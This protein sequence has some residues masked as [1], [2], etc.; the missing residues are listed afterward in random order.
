[1]TET[2]NETATVNEVKVKPTITTSAIL[3]DL[4]NGYTRT[5]KDKYYTEGK[6]ISE[7]YNLTPGQVKMLFETPS[8]KG[9]KVKKNVPFPFTVIDDTTPKVSI[10]A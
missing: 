5:P 2:V 4:E 8:L 7:K 9:K 6:S 3:K 10:T 1:M